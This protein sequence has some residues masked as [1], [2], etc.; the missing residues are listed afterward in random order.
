MTERKLPVRKCVGCNEQSGKKELMRVV[1]N[2]DGEVSL[3]PTGKKAGR[4]AYICKDVQCL[5]KARKRK[6]LE[7][8]LKCEIPAE[9]YTKTDEE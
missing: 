3:D 1:K 4:G 7:R 6:S 9:D 5:A 8:S 2:K